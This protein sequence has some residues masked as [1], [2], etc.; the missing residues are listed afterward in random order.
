M[1][2]IN[3]RNPKGSRDWLPD[4][5]IKQEFVRKSLVD[6]F[7]M[8]GYQPIQTPILIN[9]DTLSLGSSKLSDSAFKLIG[10]Q[11]EILALRADLTTPIARVAAER[12][13]GKQ[14]PFRFYYVGKVFR[15]HARK[16]TNE[17]E[18]YQIGVELIGAKE[19]I[20]DLEVLK[21]ILD[22]LNKTGLR[23]H[24]VLIN[25]TGL[26]TELFRCF[27]EQAHQLYKALSAK[28]LI[29][30]GSI[31]NKS[32]MSINEKK[33]WNELIQIR[34]S[35]EAVRKLKDL[36]KNLK[37]VKLH[38]IISYFDMVV[39]LFGNNVDVD[40]SLTSDVDYYTGI[41]F[42]VVTSHLGRSICSGGRYDQ[43][44]NKFGFDTPAVGFTFCL[45]DLLLALERQGKIF[46]KF[47]SPQF[48][49]ASKSSIKKAFNVINSLHKT[50]KHATV[51]T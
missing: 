25:H 9:W 42:E 15:Y 20:A 8:W 29:L 19:G 47:K 40:L 26:W 43:L 35:K 36:C 5:V 37:R 46:P 51:K 4:E 39:D 49:S 23:N 31:L 28:D 22:G 24:S 1:K 10:Q 16:T 3:L 50:N 45:E 14:L 38:K 11:A 34:G 12:L 6:V 30:F 21:I 44:I 32:K 41:Y 17:R 27:G 48:V 18:L 2:R 13:Q 7:E 33:F